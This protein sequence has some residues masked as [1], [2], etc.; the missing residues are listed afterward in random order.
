MSSKLP[1]Q[2]KLI[3]NYPYI[4]QNVR[5]RGNKLVYNVY[6]AWRMSKFLKLG[7]AGVV[8]ILDELVDAAD[9]AERTE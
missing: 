9:K 6:Y 3:V 1:K 5:Q 2:K 7:K 8:A 4:T